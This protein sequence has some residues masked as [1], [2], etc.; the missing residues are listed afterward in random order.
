MLTSES[1][2][3]FI[4]LFIALLFYWRSKDWRIIP[5]CFLFGFLVDIDH[6]FDYF[7]Y[8][9]LKGNFIDF[10][11]VENYMHPSGKI[12]VRFHCWE[13]V[14]LLWFLGRWLN[15]KFKIRNLEWAI[16]LSYLGHLVIDFLTVS[17][18]LL[19]Y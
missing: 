14:F 10:F 4:T 3:F 2:H 1:Y 5:L 16:S 8:F 19:A 12:Y 6:W 13:F 18:H 15:K 11:D 7:A 17:S 9:G